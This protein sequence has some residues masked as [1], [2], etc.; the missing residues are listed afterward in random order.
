[1]EKQKSLPEID[2]ST[3][4]EGRSNG[5]NIEICASYTHFP[6]KQELL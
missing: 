1:M 3:R 2:I 5:T 6:S 4:K